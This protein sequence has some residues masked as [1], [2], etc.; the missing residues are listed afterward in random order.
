M[1]L[2]VVTVKDG[3]VYD[4]VDGRSVRESTQTPRDEYL[5]KLVFLVFDVGIIGFSEI[6]DSINN[7]EN[8]LPISAVLFDSENG[9]PVAGEKHDL[10]FLDGHG[11]RNGI[12][13]EEHGQSVHYGALFPSRQVVVHR[14]VLDEDTRG[15]VLVVV[16]DGV[17]RR[18]QVRHE[19][20]A[21]VLEAGVKGHF[22]DATRFGVVHVSVHVRHFI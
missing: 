20:A 7:G 3:N 11:R 22:A 4:L 21:I 12:I 1:A 5:R 8:F 9:E 15:P 13:L 18:R 2:V 14:S 10:V 19:T 16:D 6:V 17:D